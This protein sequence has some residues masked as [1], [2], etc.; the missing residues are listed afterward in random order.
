MNDKL[1][2]CWV[3]V[4]FGSMR[5]TGKIK[6]VQNKVEF[7]KA[8][9]NTFVLEPAFE[10]H[11]PIGMNQAGGVTKSTMVLPPAHASHDTKM[12]FNKNNI[13]AYH[14]V[15]DLHE[16]DQDGYKKLVE[17]VAKMQAADR[18]HRAG[19][20]LPDNIHPLNPGRSKQ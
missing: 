10:L 12:Y 8:E 17:M 11:I 19:L 18:A 4:A 7:L 2:G 1:E 15:E 6:G 14:F 5:F 9:E 16:D 13:A 20:A 3:I